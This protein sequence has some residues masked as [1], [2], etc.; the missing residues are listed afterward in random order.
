VLQQNNNFAV[1]Q[2]PQ[3]IMD[4]RLFKFSGQFDF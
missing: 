1:W 2:T 4:G 3:R